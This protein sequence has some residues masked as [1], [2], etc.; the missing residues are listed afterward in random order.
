MKITNL[1]ICVFIGNA[2]GCK[3]M[4]QMPESVEF[5]GPENA[6][7]YVIEGDFAQ[8]YSVGGLTYDI[9]WSMS[10]NPNLGTLIGTGLFDINGYNSG[11]SV[12]FSGAVSI[13]F[14][15]KQAGSVVRVNGKMGMAGAGYVS[16]VSCTANLIYNFTNIDV[17]PLTSTMGGYVSAKGK[18]TIPGYGS[19][20]ISVPTTY[21]SQQ[22]PDVNSDGQWDSTGE[23]TAE[24]DATVDAK[25]KIVGTGELTVWD[26][27]GDP[28]DVIPQQVSGKLK[29]GVVSLAATGNSKPTSKIKVNLTYLESNEETVANKSSVSAYGQNRKF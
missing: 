11:Y 4:A 19:Q 22:L 28:Y 16:G 24:I 21:L 7:I 6:P 20:S 9:D 29:N 17:D 8:N 23:W 3:V 13:A 10:A 5:D 2:L 18:V 26:E 27:F 25:G 14:T 1:I 12:S 15:V